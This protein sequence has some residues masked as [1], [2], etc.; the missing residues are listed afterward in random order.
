MES[1]AQKLSG[2]SGPGS[3]DSEA[4]QGWLQKFGE[5]SNRLHNSVEIVFDWLY[6]DSLPW[7]AYRAFMSGRMVV[8]NKQPGVRPVGIGE[9]WRRLFSNI[10]LKFTGPEAT[11]ACQDDQLCAGLET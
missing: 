3:T 2:S 6:N 4:L 10:V 7:E 8:L 1:V 11:T 5:D 9:T